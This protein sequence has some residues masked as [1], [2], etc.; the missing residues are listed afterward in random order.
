MDLKNTF[1]LLLSEYQASS[2]SEKLWNEIESAYNQRSRHYHNLI[3]IQ[4]LFDVL[5]SL[6]EQVNDWEIIQFS[7]FYHDIIY[8]ATKSNNEEKSAELAVDRLIEIGLDTE[9]IE[10][11]KNQIVATKTHEGHDSDTKFLLDADLSI[12]GTTSQ[13]YIKYTQQIRKEYSIYPDLLYKP[14]RKKVLQHFLEM[15][16]IFKTDHFYNQLENQARQNLQ[17]ELD[18]LS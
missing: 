7:I 14:G 12:L 3:H 2:L 1:F 6:K 5:S 15:D 18:S 13:D 8:K 9:R 4:S 10:S 16:R 11:C 17:A